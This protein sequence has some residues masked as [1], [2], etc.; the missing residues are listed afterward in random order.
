MKIESNKNKI[1]LGRKTGIEVLEEVRKAKKSVKIVSPY[2]S[3]SY[4]EELLK[5]A[6]KGIK[7]TLIT[8]DDLPRGNLFS[9]FKESDVIKQGRKFV[10][11]DKKDKKDIGIKFSL[12]TL[13]FSIILLNLS[14]LFPILLYIS[15]I[16]I[17]L[18]ILLLINY[19]L[20]KTYNYEY[21]PIFNLKVFDSQ[22]GKKPESTSLIHSKIFLIDETILYLGSANFTYSAF[23]THYETVIKVEDQNAVDKISKEIDKLFSSNY[24]KVRDIQEWGKQIYE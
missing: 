8:S 19:C 10:D 21:Y 23:N 22:S 2:L 13:L 11:K 16:F 1:N 9:D 12:M 24:L 14:F 5:L 4:L 6:K 17:A 20:V 18:G 15:L 3:A 7:I